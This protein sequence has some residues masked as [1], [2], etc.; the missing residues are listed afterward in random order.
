MTL[1]IWPLTAKTGKVALRSCF[2]DVLTR[3]EHPN[4]VLGKETQVVI[5]FEESLTFRELIT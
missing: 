5:G 3:Y 1:D 2:Y 4:R